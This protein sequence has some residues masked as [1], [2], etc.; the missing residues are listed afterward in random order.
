MPICPRNRTPPEFKKTHVDCASLSD[1]LLATEVFWLAALRFGML[2]C[3]SELLRLIYPTPVH[4]I[5]YTTSDNLHLQPGT[6]LSSR[7]DRPWQSNSETPID[8][9]TAASVF[10][11]H[12]VLR[13]CRTRSSGRSSLTGET[14]CR[15]ILKSVVYKANVND[16]GG[17]NS[18]SVSLQ[19]GQCPHPDDHDST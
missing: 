16:E 7:R 12:A 1:V 14:D 3:D 6:W 5:C 8:R 18:W 4:D 13:T 10:S 17:P 15:Q 9:R 2:Q 11:T 19:H